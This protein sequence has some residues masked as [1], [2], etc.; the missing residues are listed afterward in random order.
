MGPLLYS[1]YTSNF[2]KELKFCKYHLYADDTQL[3][4]SFNASSLQVANDCINHDLQV[5][6]D[7]SKK[8]L[9]KINPKKS[10][11]LLFCSE[12][13]RPTISSGLRLSINASLSPFQESARNLGLIIDT[14]LRFKE[15]VTAKLRLAYSTLKII[16][17]QR[18]FLTQETKTM[19]CDS[20]IL[21]LVNFGIKYM[22]PA[23]IVLMLEEYKS[24]KIPVYV[25]FLELDVSSALVTSLKNWAGLTCMIVE[26]FILLASPTK[27]LSLNHLHIYSKSSV[28]DLM[29]T[30]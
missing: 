16:F 27:L 10:V 19:L 9:L 17:S 15:H 29:S 3:Y 18:H 6:Y 14:R 5:L 30:H 12:S 22:V 13:L 23:W 2:I 25:L 8:H 11:A 24:Y 7:V 28:L 1:I 4:Y 26:Y 20:L 21:S